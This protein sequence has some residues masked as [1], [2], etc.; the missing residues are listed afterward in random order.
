VLF[1]FAVTVPVRDP[2]TFPSISP[3]SLTLLLAYHVTPANVLL[4]ICVSVIVIVTVVL[5]T[6]VIFTVAVSAK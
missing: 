3:L 6:A 5:D 2:R 4:V 1:I